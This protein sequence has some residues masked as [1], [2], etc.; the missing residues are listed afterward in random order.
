MSPYD[1]EM[2][3]CAWRLKLYT[4]AKRMTYRDIDKAVSEGTIN[5]TMT[6]AEC[7]IALKLPSRMEVTWTK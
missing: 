1:S 3:Y 2:A 7:C 4:Y 6:P 5:P